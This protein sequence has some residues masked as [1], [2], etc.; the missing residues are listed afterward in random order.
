LEKY[1]DDDDEGHV[2]VKQRISIDSVLVTF[3]GINVHDI[4]CIGIN[5]DD[6]IGTSE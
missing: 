3:T 2:H 4:K 1:I 6:V 5:L